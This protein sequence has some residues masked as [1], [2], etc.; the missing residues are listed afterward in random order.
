VQVPLRWTLLRRLRMSP[1]GLA[2][3]AGDTSQVPSVDDA[4][5]AALGERMRRD[6]M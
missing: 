1:H 5:A 4:L 3:H 2:A 6:L